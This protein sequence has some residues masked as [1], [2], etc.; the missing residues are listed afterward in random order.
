MAYTN[1]WWIPN[2]IVYT[3][4]SGVQTKEELRACIKEIH[5]YLDQGEGLRVHVISD[6]SEL[7]QG[8]S[9]VQTVRIAKEFPIHPK[10]GW[11]ITI[12]EVSP[13][14]AMVSLLARNVLRLKQANFLS[15]EE[16]LKFL[17]EVDPEIDWSRKQVE[18]S[19]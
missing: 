14:I 3:H 11:S 12:G 16:A 8:L 6:M 5:S 15:L 7:Q 1:R 10:N 2:H 18:I 19:A 4:Y 9:F 17:A 13:I